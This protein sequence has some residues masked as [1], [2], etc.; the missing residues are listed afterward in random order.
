MKNL[1]SLVANG[2]VVDRGALA[3]YS[4]L[5]LPPSTR[6]Q[7]E[8]VTKRNDGG[9][10]GSSGQGKCPRLSVDTASIGVQA[11]LSASIPALS[12]TPD[13]EKPVFTVGLLDREA[14]VAGSTYSNSS[15]DDDQQKSG[16]PPPPQG[17]ARDL[18]P[19]GPAR[20]QQKSGS[21]PPFL[22]DQHETWTPVW[23]SSSQ[24]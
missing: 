4:S 7:E 24:K 15:S 3:G 17:P 21:P 16:S 12:I 18:D 11:D 6:R 22:R 5:A 13:R 19:Q 23:I 20:D 2:I 10:T 9:T 14:S 8:S 1:T